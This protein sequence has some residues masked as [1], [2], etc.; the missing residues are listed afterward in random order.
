MGIELRDIDVNEPAEAPAPSTETPAKQ[1]EEPVEEQEIETP[2]P[3][4]EPAQEP[5]EEPAKVQKSE[6]PVKPQEQ[7]QP[8]RSRATER[9]KEVIQENKILKQQLEQFSQ[10]KAPELQNE[11]IA[12]DDL[13]KVINERALQAAELI[14]A[15]QRV[16]SELQSHAKMWADDFAQ[17]KK[18]NPQLDPESQH[19]DRELD[20]TLAKLLDDGNGMP[21]T[22]ILVSEVLSTMKRREAATQAKALEQG[23]SQASAKL[24]QQQAE[25]AITPTP[26]AP[27]K[28]EEGLSD[29]ESES[30]RTSNPKEWFKRL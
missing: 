4:E 28:S 8:K 26:K 6:E 9:I 14:V 19:Y 25:G 7:E 17:V 10:Q 24:A 11:E 21:R 16:N 29:E 3:A 23:K 18:D 2:E 15:S 20:V 5:A 22:D 13:N 1:V 12:Y 30:L 27:G